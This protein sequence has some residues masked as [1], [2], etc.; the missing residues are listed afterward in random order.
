MLKRFENKEGKVVYF[1][2]EDK[3]FNYPKGTLM[4][5]ATIYPVGPGSYSSYIC[6]TEPIETILS[7]LPR[8]AEHFLNSK[9]GSYGVKEISD[10]IRKHIPELTFE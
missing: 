7:A 5:E 2:I 1:S 10:V 6:T 9:Q 3:N 8:I 4:V